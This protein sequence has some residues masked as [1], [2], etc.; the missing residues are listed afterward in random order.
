MTIE[1]LFAALRARLGAF[2]TVLLVTMLC[3][4]VASVLLPKSY[5]ATASVMAD[6]KDEQSLSNAMHPLISPQERL[7]YLQTQVDVITSPR[8]AQMVVNDLK[9]AQDPAVREEFESKNR[10]ASTIEEW[11]VEGLLQS[12][13][14]ET[15]QSSILRITFVS[16][17][18]EFA[19]RAA[20]AFAKA[21]LRTLLELR[22]EPTRQAAA[23][24]QEQIKALRTNL[25]TAQSKLT[26][27]QR[28][29]GIVSADEHVD[30]ESLSLRELAS[31]LARV[32]DQTFEWGARERQARDAARGGYADIVPDV[33]NN[34]QM[35]KLQADLTTAE[36]RLV[37]LEA[38]L[39]PNHPNYQRQK[40]EVRELRQRINAQSSR[41]IA[42]FERARQQS[43]QREADLRAAMKAQRERLLERKV[44][45]NE[46]AVLAA[47]VDTAQRTY[48]AAMQRFVISQVDSRANQTNV[49]LLSRAEPPREPFRPRLWLNLALAFAAGTLLGFGVIVAGETFDRRVRTAKDLDFG[50]QAPLLAVFNARLGA[51]GTARLLLPAR[52]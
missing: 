37:E 24:F 21:Y 26:E 11:L 22:V 32:Q 36:G 20:N 28:Q 40:S 3:A 30:V 9:L 27:Y 2:I 17:D 52:R 43:Q 41:V 33:L 44:N 29:Q 47:D 18:S 6:A 49:S 46:V 19:A 34:P 12:L 1:T 13:K 8:V 35:Q 42:G 50:A 5:R 15:S 4:A 31:Q 10:G 38:Q 25:Q 48:D 51:G 23:W 14:V 16:R 39:G 45:R 7:G